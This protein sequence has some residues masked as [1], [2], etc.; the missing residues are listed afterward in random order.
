MSVLPP[1]SERPTAVR[2]TSRPRVQTGA[3]PGAYATSL[4]P[5]VPP[6]LPKP[7][8]A[9][10]QTPRQTVAN[11]LRRTRRAPAKEMIDLKDK[12]K[13]SPTTWAAFHQE[14]AE[15]QR[16]QLAAAALDLQPTAASERSGK[17]ERTGEDLP[18][19]AGLDAAIHTTWNIG[20][21]KVR[22]PKRDTRIAGPL[23]VALAHT[24]VRAGAQRTERAGL[25]DWAKPPTEEELATPAATRLRGAVPDTSH[26]STAFGG[27]TGRGI[28]VLTQGQLHV[29]DT[30]RYAAMFRDS[31]EPGGGVIEAYHS[32]ITGGQPVDAAGEIEIRDGRVVAI[33]NLSGHYRPGP[34]HLLNTLSWLAGRG[35]DVSGIKV[36]VLDRNYDAVRFV[37][38]GGDVAALEA[39]GL[40]ARGVVIGRDPVTGRT[41][42]SILHP[43]EGLLSNLSVA[44]QQ[45]ILSEPRGP[46]SGSVL[47]K[48]A[49]LESEPRPLPSAAGPV[50]EPRSPS[51][52]D[53]VEQ[54]AT[55]A[56]LLSGRRR[57][58]VAQLR[59]RF[60]GGT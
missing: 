1:E 56:N 47:G 15:K 29:T 59:D 32:S 34:E 58:T 16:I 36:G 30:S 33:S 10:P 39:R 55:L 23:P 26:M 31:E 52:A 51:S 43:T 6:P 8:P 53:F 37:K 24:E 14:L 2:G 22:D 40:A 25:L 45:R 54:R 11:L 41:T 27:S 9:Q 28:F 50:G 5:F 57:G 12:R 4:A 44:A 46:L 21:S 18:I 35:I 48:V 38:S 20:Y 13:D 49:E 3:R 19:G 17:D 42:A 7:A 60:S